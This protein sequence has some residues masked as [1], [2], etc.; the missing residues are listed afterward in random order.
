MRNAINCYVLKHN[1]HGPC[2]DLANGISAN[3]TLWSRVVPV[4]NVENVFI[5]LIL[6][7]P[8]YSEKQNLNFIVMLNQLLIRLYKI[9]VCTKT[10]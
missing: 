5:R 7:K 3:A 8:F 10:K 1:F 4:K 9:S 6:V 2:Y